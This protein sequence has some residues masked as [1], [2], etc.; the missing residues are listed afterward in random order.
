MNLTEIIKELI[1]ERELLD[2]AIASV[3]RLAAQ[4]GRRRGRPPA[5]LTLL[6]E[7]PQA[8]KPRGRPRRIK[9]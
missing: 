4:R 9:E 3:E 7:A 6:N 5:W 1:E 8:P 2:R